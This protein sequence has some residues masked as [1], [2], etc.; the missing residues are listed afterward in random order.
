MIVGD[1]V[2]SNQQDEMD[3]PSLGYVMA[4]QNCLRSRAKVNAKGYNLSVCTCSIMK[5]PATEALRSTLISELA[6]NML[7][8]S[9]CSFDWLA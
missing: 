4:F 8:V 2:F 9:R 7:N 3:N 6:G 5:S 1:T